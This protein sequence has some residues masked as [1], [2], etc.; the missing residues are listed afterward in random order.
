MAKNIV[1]GDRGLLGSAFIRSMKGI[2]DSFYTP[3]Y[4]L[5]YS[6]SIL[7]KVFEDFEIENVFLC[8]YNADVNSSEV[9]P[10]SAYETN[11]VGNKKIIDAANRVGAKI[12]FPSSSYV[13]SGNL[14][15][16]YAYEENDEVNPVSVYGRHKVF[17]EEYIQKTSNNYLIFRTVSVFGEEA[18][19]KN[20]V[21]QVLGAM[22]HGELFS[23]P[24]DQFVNPI[25]SDVLVTAVMDLVE[26]KVGGIYHIAGDV[27]FSK[28]EWANDIV[29][30]HPNASVHN[31][32]SDLIC[33]RLSDEKFAAR[34]MNGM[35]DCSK[36]ETRLGYLPMYDIS[37]FINDVYSSR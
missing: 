11:V 33:G 31:P 25:S 12:V 32:F 27:N 24:L 36:L 6:Y 5:G 29:S 20:F 17:L 2:G 8:A 15:L 10:A 13:F 1:F 30:F 23:A 18:K 34:P 35:L 4:K 3:Y 7:E 16:S 26:R 9:D 14:N 37:R 19:Q 22:D 28:F 21:Y